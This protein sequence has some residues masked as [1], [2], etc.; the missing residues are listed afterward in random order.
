[1]KVRNLQ[2]SSPQLVQQCEKTVTM[3][4]VMNQQLMRLLRGLD[5]QKT[6]TPDDSP[7]K[8]FLPLS[9]HS[10]QPQDA[11]NRASVMRR[12]I[13]T[14]CFLYCSLHLILTCSDKLHPTY[15]DYINFVLI[16]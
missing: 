2:Q 10:A 9:V 16:I 4:E 13:S 8:L 1:M 11:D 12:E 6:P 14:G 7:A 5:T 3:M 15:G